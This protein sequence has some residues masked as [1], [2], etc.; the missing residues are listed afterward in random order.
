MHLSRLS[1]IIADNEETIEA[2][3]RDEACFL[4]EPGW[5][6]LTQLSASPRYLRQEKMF[7]W[8]AKA[9][10]LFRDSQYAN[11]G[12]HDAQD[13][14]DR[15]IEMRM[16][17][18][19][20]FKDWWD[21]LSGDIFDDIERP[22]G[23]A[24]IPLAYW[25]PNVVSPGLVCSH[26]TVLILLNQLLIDSDHV[27]SELLAAESRRAAAEICKCVFQ[28]QT[29]LLMSIYMPYWL[30]VAADGCAPEH[31]VWIMSKLDHF[32][33]AKVVGTPGGGS[34]PADYL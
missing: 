3:V 18:K 20:H 8:H 22:S 16:T 33:T 11:Q 23:D 4:E 25:F 12:Q 34:P 28:S 5:Q 1:N 2:F 17:M 26:Y 7:A 9:P 15:G 32:R 13:V 10:R 31:Y 14:I 29:R 19:Q 24:V 21:D 30:R 27:D 6:A